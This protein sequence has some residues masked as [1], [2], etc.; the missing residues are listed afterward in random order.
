MNDK[1]NQRKLRK[2]RSKLIKGTQ[3][4]PR[5]VIHKS[6]LYLTVQAIDDA[7]G[8]TLV[9]S[10]TAGFSQNGTTISFKNKNWSEKLGETFADQLKQNGIKEIV[11]DR[12]GYLYHGKIK[13]FCE[14]MRQSGIKF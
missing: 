10:S 14:T 5:V 8:H 9:Y 2:K 3:K 12:N 7:Q 4:K 11:F 6:N 13:K 1:N